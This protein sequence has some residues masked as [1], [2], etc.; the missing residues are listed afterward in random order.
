MM[1]ILYVRIIFYLF[2]N[3]Y[4]CL[5]QLWI[6]NNQLWIMDNWLCKFFG[7]TRIFANNRLN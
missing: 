2:E 5:F 4:K 7:I 6:V 1:S 3:K